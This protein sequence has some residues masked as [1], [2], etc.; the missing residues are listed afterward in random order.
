MNLAIARSCQLAHIQSKNRMSSSG[1][2]GE[3]SSWLFRPMNLRRMSVP[4]FQMSNAWRVLVS[5]DPLAIEHDGSD[6]LELSASAMM[7]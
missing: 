3:A 6:G 4:L 5:S 1:Q 2:P 7:R